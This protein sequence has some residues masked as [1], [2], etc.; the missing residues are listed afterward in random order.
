VRRPQ[1]VDDVDSSR[2]QFL[3][4]LSA[5]AFTAPR[6][7]ARR[8]EGEP[9][10]AQ[11]KESKLLILGGT[12]FLGPQVIEAA[13]AR[14]HTVTLFNRGR[15]NPELFPDLEKLRGDRNGDLAAL[16]GREWDAVVD[17]SAYFPRQVRLSAGLLADSVRH[18]VLVSTC[19]VYARLGEQDVDE[20]SELARLEDET[21]ESVDAIAKITGENY[22]ALKAL[23]EKE[24]E[25]KMPGRVANVRPG[26][27]VGPGDGSDRFTYWPAR[28][29]RGGE[30][31]AP[32]EPSHTV[33]FVDV[34]DLGEWIVGLIERRSAG[35]FNA[36]GP[37][38]PLSMATLLE[39]CR[40]AAANDARL[41]WVPA[42]F[43]AEQNVQP[44]S[45]MPVWTPPP[46]GRSDVPAISNA[47][48]R[49]AGLRFRT[50]DAIVADTLAW[51]RSR[52]PDREL[53][54]GLKPERERDVLA[55]WHARQAK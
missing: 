10:D 21:P 41:T 45:D 3:A 12:A 4:A 33:Q 16:E 55:A 49:E 42:A 53:R 23:C 8:Q 2:R 22:G 38:Q 35:A 1:E 46:E 37:E 7:F 48:A 27:I 28:L 19:S 6:A 36:V 25:S 17:T 9:Q 52:G 51:H 15:T 31:L 24:A 50:L 44:W 39:A 18:Y 5:L 30:V 47:K 43:L 14:G 20:G 34:R 40:R 32:G 54:A 13:L 26:L 29:A 11:R